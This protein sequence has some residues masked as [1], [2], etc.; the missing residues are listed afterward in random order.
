M[1]FS[2]K[3]L[4]IGST[5]F[6][7]FMMFAVMDGIGVAV[8]FAVLSSFVGFTLYGAIKNWQGLKLGR[9]I[10]GLTISIA[11][12]ILLCGFFYFMA[13]DASISR[14]RTARSIQRN[15]ANKPSFDNITITYEETKIEYLDVSGSVKKIA[16][17]MAS[18]RKRFLKPTGRAWTQFGGISRFSIP[19]KL[20]INWTT[21]HYNCDITPTADNNLMH[22]NPDLRVVLKWTIARSTVPAR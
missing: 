1:R 22:A 19:V 11:A 7:T 17:T 9:R 14:S 8:I 5:L 16:R 13:T 21:N 3:Q 2:I 15:L 10:Y 6:S 18:S 20:L 4:L 12:T